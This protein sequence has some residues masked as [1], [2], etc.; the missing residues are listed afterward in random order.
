M[1]NA[2]CLFCNR[3]FEVTFTGKKFCNKKCANSYNSKRRNFR[4]T[5]E[6]KN[7]IR[8]SIYKYYESIGKDEKSRMK[9]C[10]KCGKDFLP[11]KGS[12]KYC[13]P[14]CY[15]KSRKALNKNEIAYRTFHKILKRAFP[16]WKCP[17]CDWN[18][19]FAVHH[20]DGRKNNSFDSLIMLCPNH[21][22]LAHIGGLSK[23]EMKRYA[24]GNIYTKEQ[25][26]NK[27]Y[28]GNNK[29]VNFYKYEDK[30]K[31]KERAKLRAKS[32]IILKKEDQK[33]V[34]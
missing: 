26:L 6:Q 18:K 12:R 19:T 8:N 2:T 21:H 33:Y 11:N 3:E 5:T 25:L 29:D 7:K 16:D 15:N 31:A 28:G 27:Y 22:S 34:S 9:K 13:S 32:M 20:I 1:S 10:D 24:I 14:E 23:E 30:N 4:F 17:F